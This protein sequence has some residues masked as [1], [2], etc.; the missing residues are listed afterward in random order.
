MPTSPTISP[1]DC[2]ATPHPNTTNVKAE[3]VQIIE[4]TVAG[5]VAP[6]QKFLT[7]HPLAA[8]LCCCA[9]MAPDPDAPNATPAVAQKALT[10]AQIKAAEKA[11]E[12]AAKEHEKTAAGDEHAAEETTAG[13][14]PEHAVAT[15][16]AVPLVPYLIYTV[17]L[18]H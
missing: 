8:I 6:L 11:A 2:G 1:N 17:G 13:E 12:K 18:V 9:V 16:S 4:G 3:E 10:P 15:L 14:K 5:V 7:S